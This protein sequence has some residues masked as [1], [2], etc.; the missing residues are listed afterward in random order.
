MLP[1]LASGATPTRMRQAVETPRDADGLVDYNT[2]WRIWNDMARYY[3]SAVHRRRLIVDWLR[4]LAPATV[5]DVGCGTGILLDHL[6]TELP[7]VRQFTGVDYA[8]ETCEENGRRLPWARFL[9]LDL[10]KAHL[11]EKFDA[12]ICSEVLEHVVEGDAALANLVAMTGKY[13]LITVPTGTLF[14]LEAGFGHLRHYRL[15]ELCRRIEGHGLVVRRSEAWGFPWMNAFK[16]ASNV[17]PKAVMEAFGGGDWSWPK[18]LVGAALTGLFYF[19]L[20]RWGPQ[21]IVLAE[22]P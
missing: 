3:P 14:P 4:P 17:R 15:E 5:A 18:K 9:P 2:G 10:G 8:H 22:R 6:R 20:H 19:N 21:L 13:L 7:A 16:L 12:V 11:D 1:F